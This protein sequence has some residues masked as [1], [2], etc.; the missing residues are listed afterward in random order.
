V[1]LGK[2]GDSHAWPNYQHA[3]GGVQ[4][5]ILQ[6][7]ASSVRN[8]NYRNEASGSGRGHA[9]GGSLKVHCH[10]GQIR[11]AASYEEVVRLA[12]DHAQ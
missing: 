1:R 3:A 7:I 8:E 2:T 10:F 6:L 5:Q 11:L 12:Q 4:L 9:K